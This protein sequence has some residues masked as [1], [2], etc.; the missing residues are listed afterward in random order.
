[1]TRRRSRLDPGNTRRTRQLD[2]VTD[3]ARIDKHRT[4]MAASPAA[5]WEATSRA[6]EASMSGAV[7]TA[8]ASALGCRNV[9]AAG[10]RP[11]RT[12]SAFCGFQVAVAEPPHKLVLAGAHRFASY[13]LILRI[14]ATPEGSRLRAESRARFPGWTGRI[15]RALVIGTGAHK[16]A[17]RRLLAAIKR[18]AKNP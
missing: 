12:G 10:P 4:V 14:D 5:T 16:I 11:L 6:I 9:C 7:G 1:M 8:I 2:A 17:M 13:G 3:L 18:Q 15:Y